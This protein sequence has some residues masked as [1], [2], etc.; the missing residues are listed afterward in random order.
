MHLQHA[1]T[2]HINN[3]QNPYAL[4]GGVG[5]KALRQIVE[6][7]YRVADRCLPQDAV[8]IRKLASD[9]TKAANALCDLRQDGKGQ[10][11]QA[12]QLTREIR[13]KLGDLE[14]AVHKAVIGI[15]KGGHQ[16]AAHTVN[17]EFIQR[18]Y[19]YSL[20]RF[21]K[22]SSMLC[23]CKDVWIKHAVGFKIPASTTE[24]LANVR[25]I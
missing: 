22:Y 11:P 1:L 8:Q 17:V 12:N 10:T 9:I 20:L 6:N 24:V 3:F 19:N 21:N 23:R 18:Q 25:L 15:E 16:Q 7:A 14:Q 4:R 5:E 2:K 13:E